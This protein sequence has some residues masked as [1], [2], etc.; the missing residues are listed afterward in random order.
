M[1]RRQTVPKQWLII[2][3]ADD[4]EGLAA[5]ARLRPGSG[6]ILLDSLPAREMR[7][8]RLRGVTIVEE[9]RGSTARMH[10][11]G[12]LRR[13]L[14]KRTPFILLS[15]IYPTQSHPGWK[16]IPRMRAAALAR[17]GGRRLVALGGMDA[18]KFAR[19]RR[20]GFQAWAGVSAFRT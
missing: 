13:A 7:K 2:R 17:L 4:R 16:P 9:R 3:S 10:N 5:A 11:L 8:L 6:V 20:I 15:P 1:R 12:E 19:I 18:R 14:L